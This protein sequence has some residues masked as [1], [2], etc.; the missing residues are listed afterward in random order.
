METTPATMKQESKVEQ[1]KGKALGKL[2]A[3]LALLTLMFMGATPAL[4]ADIDLTATIGPLLESVAELMPGFGALIVAVL[5]WVI[6]LAVVGFVLKFLDK[7]LAI[8][9]KII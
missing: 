5:P 3:F 7:I 4:A 9:D 8:F 1:I 2:R 6:L